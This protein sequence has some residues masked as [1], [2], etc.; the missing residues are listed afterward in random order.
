MTHTDVQ[1]LQLSTELRD[2]QSRVHQFRAVIRTLGLGL[3][4]LPIDD[5]AALTTTARLGPQARDLRR[6]LELLQAQLPALRRSVARGRDPSTHGRFGHVKGTAMLVLRDLEQLEQEL[7]AFE[8]RIHAHMQ[9]PGRY[10]DAAAGGP[11]AELVG[12]LNGL[13]DILARLREHR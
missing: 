6:R 10:G 2:V 13:L 1:L 9:A 8:R 11:V 7:R 4:S 12:L 3:D 5:R